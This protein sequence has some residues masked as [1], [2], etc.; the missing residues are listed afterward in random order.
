MNLGCGLSLSRNQRVGA[1]GAPW[2]PASISGLKLWLRTS[3]LGQMFQDSGST[4]PVT[5]AADPVYI[6]NDSGPSSLVLSAGADANRPFLRSDA[7]RLGS[8]HYTLSTGN[9]YHQA[10]SSNTTFNFI[11]EIA[12]FSVMCWVKFDA[13]DAT[14]NG[15]VLANKPATNLRGF[16]LRRN[17][18]ET[19]TFTVANGATAGLTLTS[20]ATIADTSWHSIV[21]KST[22]GANAASL[23][24]DGGTPVTAT[25]GTLNSGNANSNLFLGVLNDGT[26]PMLGQL[27]EL[28]IT[29]TV[30]TDDEV[31][32][33]LAYNP[34][35]A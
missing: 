9:R 10:A 13:A 28:V 24:I 16:H 17:T 6:F 19:M 33:W 22:P 15:Y 26:L 5:A 12:T 23:T 20:T 29:N 35:L 3:K 8:M 11:H 1:S 32:N 25:V 7:T 21:V 27:S 31:T 18:T 2:T 30:V 14:A 34:A 4:T